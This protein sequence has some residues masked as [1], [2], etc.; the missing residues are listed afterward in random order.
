MRSLVLA[1]LLTL[2]AFVA[3]VLFTKT[4]AP[5]AAS[6][7]AAGGTLDDAALADLRKDNQMLRAQI[8]ALAGEISGLR[9]SLPEHP[10]AIVNPAATPVPEPDDE[11]PG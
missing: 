8:A 7:P 9:A 11:P 1:L 10:V 3:G 4:A 5:M 2:A 6:V